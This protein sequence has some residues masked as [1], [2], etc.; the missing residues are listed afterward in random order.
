[1]LP[2]NKFNHMDTSD[3]HKMRKIKGSGIVFFKNVN[4]LKN[5]DSLWNSSRLTEAEEL[6]QLNTAI[7]P[8]LDPR[9]EGEML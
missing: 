9:L 5:Q 3:N 4:V 1:M 6:W 8:R 2:E 7:D